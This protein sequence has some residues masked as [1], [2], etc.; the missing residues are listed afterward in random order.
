MSRLPAVEPAGADASLK[1]MFDSFIAERGAVPNMFRTLAHAPAL[2]RT[3]FE[4]FRAV[5]AEGDVS[6]R[7]KEMIA[8]R[9][10]SL[11][12]SRY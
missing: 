6:T 3:F 4:H 10:S 1:P 8:V 11:N 9:V 2:L 7:V 12:A 5:L